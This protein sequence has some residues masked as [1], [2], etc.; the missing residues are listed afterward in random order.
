MRKS[1]LKLA[2]ILFLFGMAVEIGNATA[3]PIGMHFNPQADLNTENIVNCDCDIPAPQVQS[4]TDFPGG[5]SV[6]L[7]NGFVLTCL[8]WVTIPDQECNSADTVQHYANGV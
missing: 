1:I 7:E 4:I 8:D 5:L 6:T 3:E 2:A